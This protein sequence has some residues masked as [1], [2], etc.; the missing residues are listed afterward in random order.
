MKKIVLIFAVTLL[1]CCNA[2][3]GREGTTIFQILNIPVSAY[4]ASLS[5]YKYHKNAKSAFNAG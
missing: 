5:N 4:D 3:A 1:F 2:F